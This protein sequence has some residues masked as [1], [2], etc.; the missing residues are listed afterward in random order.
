M[1]A[2]N[3]PV[4]EPMVCTGDASTNWKMFK[5]AYADYA[6][7][8]ELQKKD[9]AIQAATLKTIMGKECRQIL[10]R[11]E[12]SETESKDPA[13]VLAKLEAYFE[14]A[15][16]ILY[17]RF[18]FHGAE[19]L[20]NEMIDQYIIRLRRLAETCNFQGLH[21][22]MVRDRLVLGCRD[23]AARARLFRQKECDLKTALESLRISERTLEQLKQLATEE[24]EVPVNAI[25]KDRHSKQHRPPITY[26]KSKDSRHAVL[27]NCCGGKQT[28][29]HASCPAYGKSCNHCGKPNHFQAVCRRKKDIR[30]TAASL[31][32]VEE[33]DVTSDS[34]ESAFMIEQVG[35]VHHN[36]K[37]Q[38]FAT[39]EFVSTSGKV[40]LDCQLDTGATCNVITH[41]DGAI[42]QQNGEPI[43]Q[44]SST[45][46]KFYDGSLVLAL[47]EYTAT[48]RYGNKTHTPNFKVIHGDQRP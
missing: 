48:C 19:Q 40:V 38:Y 39:L 20:P 7:A 4:P 33:G 12:L 16:N 13:V 27:C 41:R 45:R 23:K 3:L 25:R 26:P 11:L 44:P 5:E 6:T 36:K 37:G 21:D 42:I 28:A 29:D 46:L 32:A 18:L 2:Y 24:Q 9:K 14:P 43:L 30:K 17:E 31:A 10:A 34:D 35:A 47:G 22:E 15:R 1:A 8:T